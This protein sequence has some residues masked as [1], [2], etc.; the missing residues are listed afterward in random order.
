[1]PRPMPE[2]TPVTEPFWSALR[3]HRIRIQY[4][5]SAGRYVFYPRVRAPGTL[6]DDLEWRN[7]G[8]LG[9]CIPSRSAIGRRRPVS[10]TTFRSCS[11][12]WSGTRSPAEHRVGQRR[13]RR[14]AGR[15]AGAP[16]LH[17]PTPRT[18]SRC[19]AT[20]RIPTG[21]PCAEPAHSRPR[22]DTF[23]IFS[24]VLRGI[25]SR[26]RNCSGQVCL[27]MPPRGEMR[28]DVGHGQRHSGAELD[29]GGDLLAE[30]VMRCT[31]D[32]CE[33][34]GGVREAV[35]ASTSAALMFIPPR[36]MM[37]ATRPDTVRYPSGDRVARSGMRKPPATIEQHGVGR[38]VAQVPG[39]HQRTPA[40]WLSGPA[41]TAD[42]LRR[43][44]GR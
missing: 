26:M 24:P 14:V 1:M 21:Y 17:G 22:R 3:E 5:P 20:N 29:E 12:S 28:L 35:P 38:V 43:W 42:A 32:R 4:S 41:G 15:D 16:G 25:S 6:A 18:A 34:H 11:R 23:A 9:R 33:F 10:R 27:A 19:C 39:G 30:G 2:P 36:M 44:R 8:G 40:G 13:P 37:S 7:I 31:D